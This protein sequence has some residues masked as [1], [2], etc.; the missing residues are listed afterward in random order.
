MVW[1][2][3]ALVAALGIAA[4]A[5][6]NRADPFQSA[7]T[8][9]GLKL[10]RM[11]P[12]LTPHLDGIIDGLPAKVDIAR[13]Q[14][15]YRVFYPALG[16]ALHLEKET[17]VDRTLGKLGHGDQQI[18][19]TEFDE[20]FRVNTS[21]PDALRDMLTPEVRRH[22]T[23]L[24][25]RY[26]Q[27]VISDGEISL[28]GRSLEP[29]ADEIV[30]T[31]QDIAAVARLLDSNRP[32]PR[33]ADAPLP[34]IPGTTAPAEPPAQPP[35]TQQSAPTPTN[36]PTP[37]PAR[38]PQ[39]SE[40]GGLPADFFEDAFGENRLSFEKDD[41][42]EREIKGTTITLTGVVRQTSVREEERGSDGDE[43]RTKAV[44][45]VAHIDSSLYGKAEIDAVVHL[46]E[47]VELARGETITFTGTADRIDP[48]MRNLYITDASLT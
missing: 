21:R 42:F 43:G 18:G 20:R 22:L 6:L 1:L 15:R 17:T 36:P 10:S 28:L 8:D 39:S 31:V 29:P 35:E 25:D 12:E 37:K 40:T 27:V 48:F 24:I 26:P 34:F 38:P 44:V 45:N 16:M 30:T 13:N 32:P 3:V 2:I 11:V 14:V 4:A 41:R 23:D 19:I 7:S 47:A 46:R 5:L 33:S 9:L